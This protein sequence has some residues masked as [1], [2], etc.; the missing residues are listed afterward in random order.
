MAEQPELISVGEAA[1]RLQRSTEQV[2]RYL[3]EGRLP[4]RRLGG[5]WFIDAGAVAA[6]VTTS[7]QAP[8]TARLRR[9]DFL[10]R[11]RND[12]NGDPLGE[13]IAVTSGIGTDIATGKLG[14][15]IAYQQWRGN[16]TD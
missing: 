11:L 15:R 7:A 3:R 10:A 12:A 4:G 13:T 1:R 16:G 8:D 6:F 14:Y 5:Q 9:P 2:R